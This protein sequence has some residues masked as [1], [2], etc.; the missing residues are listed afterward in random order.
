MALDLSYASG[1]ST[2]PLTG[3]TIGQYFDEIVEKYPHNEALVIPHQGVR[4]TYRELDEEVNMIARALLNAGLKKGER[5]GIWAPNCLEWTLTQYAT[6]KLGAILVNINP[7]YRLNELEYALNQ[8]ECHFIV[9]AE[10]Y[11]YSDYTEMLQELLPE[12]EFCQPG[13]LHAARAPHLRK[14]ITLAN[15]APPGM[16]S[17]NKLQFLADDVPTE[18]VQ[19]R[20]ATLS[21]DDPINIQYTSGTTGFPKGATLSHHNILNNARMTGDILGY[22]E[23]TRIVVPVPLYHCFGMV[24][25]NLGAMTHGA[26]AIYPSETFDATEVLKTVERERGTSLYG[27]PTMFIACLN[28]PDFESYDLTSL[29]T[30]IMAGAPC[31]IEVMRAVKEHMHMPDI[32][33]AYGMT[34]TSPVTTQTRIGT[35]IE[36][37]VSTVGQVH[38]WQEVKIVDP[39][40][41]LTVPIGERGEV[42][43]RG[44]AI[45]LGYW[46]NEKRT[47]ETID[48]ARWIHSGDL[49]TMDEDGYVRIVGRIKDMIIRGGENIYPREIE[50][51]LHAHPAIDNVQ[52]IGI[53]DEKY[54]E[55]VMAWIKL[56]PGESLTEEEIKAY[57]K[58]NIAYYKIPRFFR[59]TDEFPMTVTGKIRKIEMKEISIR[60]MG[61]VGV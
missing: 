32:Q 18:R 55:E 8:S 49:G 11:K 14:V 30:G 53:P 36:L 5:L 35:P 46:D 50:E 22:T 13:R 23:R 33:C 1:S 58:G 2:I 41:G 42:C 3:L 52:V 34:E 29:R 45:M 17:W 31:P 19:E 37:Q 57:C 15:E 27:V 10:K 54:G 21:C 60:E 47:R 48:S 12:L 51:F 40:T 39:E 38:P 6:A 4:L 24:L 16:I 20:S 44:Y 28:E 9:A 25:G 61:L 59:F 7:S 43:M 26:T 56:K